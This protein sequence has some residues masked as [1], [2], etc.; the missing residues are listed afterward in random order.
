M[1]FISIFNDVLGPVMRGPSSS[2]TAG[3][4]RIGLIARSLLGEEPSAAHLSFDPQGSYA[5]TYQEQGADCGFAAGLLGWPITDGRFFHA[6]ELAA[7][8]GL[9]IEFSV[10]P[11]QGATHP[12]TV[13]IRLTGR[14]GET[15]RA[16]AQSTGGG[17][18]VFKRV[19]GWHVDITGKSYELLVGC[20]SSAGTPAAELV[21]GLTDITGKADPEGT[22]TGRLLHF[23]GPTPV[24]EV[25]VSQIRCL[26]GVRF[27]REVVP[28]FFVQRGEPIVRNAAEM[29]ARAEARRVSLG[30]IAL[31][32]ESILLGF[33]EKEAR[34]EMLQRWDVMRTAV[35]DGLRDEAVRMKLL[36]PSAANILRAETEGRLAA[37]GLHGRAA[38]RAMAG[39]HISSSGGV[40]CAAPTGASSGV[41]PGVLVTLEEEKKLSEENIAL[42]MFAAA[43]VGLVVARRAT[44][45]AEEAGCQVEI[46]AAGAMAAAAVVEA[47]GGTAR[48]ALDAA[49][50]SLQ[51]SMGSV[52]DLVQGICEVPCHTRTAAAAASAFICADLVL[53]GYVNPVPLDETVDAVYAVGKM[54]PPELRCTSLGGLAMTSAARSMPRLR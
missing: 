19:N 8:E 21:E 17:L 2:H 43:A 46:G 44:F 32:F 12:N 49:A 20:D 34:Q 29:A 7:R 27:V 5:R 31:E 48:Q 52:C 23:I 6:R 11:L 24:S 13:D 35:G 3:S 26:P 10:G 37:G 51:N 47:T 14:S 36:H 50:V 45:A 28:V 16:V 9:P 42:A 4:Y 33:S 18:V 53:G 54:L 1:D 25:T 22:Q 40:V 41:L 15:L 39:L 30:R 38:A